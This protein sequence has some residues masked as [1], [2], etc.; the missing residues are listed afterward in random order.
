MTAHKIGTLVAIPIK[1]RKLVNRTGGKQSPYVQLKLGEQK[2]RTRASLIASV[3]VDVFQD[4]LDMKVSVFDEGKKGELVGDGILLLN[5]V[6]DKGELDVWFPIK[7]NGSAAGDIYF[8][9]TF[10]AAAPPPAAGSTPPPATPQTQIHTPLRYNQPGF[11][12]GAPGMHPL[13]H[14]PPVSGYGSPAINH[15][16]NL[17][18]PSP[19][20]AGNMYQAP[21]PGG[22]MPNANARPFPPAHQQPFPPQQ[23]GPGPLPFG[24]PPAVSGP[25]FNQPPPFGN[26][27]PFRPPVGGAFPNPASPPFGQPGPPGSGPGPIGGGFPNAMPHMPQPSFNNNNG[28]N[29]G[30]NNFPPHN[31]GPNNNFSP[32]NNNMGSRFPMPQGPGGPNNNMNNGPNFLQGPGG[33]PNT[34]PNNAPSSFPNGPNNNNFNNGPPNSFPGGNISNHNNLNNNNNFGRNNNNNMPSGPSGNN[35]GP[36]TP[37]MQYNYSL[38]GSFP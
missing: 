22:Y 28:P 16:M 37:L 31:N 11:Q 27:A 34:F 1:G 8:E 30:P 17:G 18:G 24:G 19:P 6:I 20:Y 36:V 10:Y 26:N 15:N 2:K 23:P 25:G 4:Q 32:N 14:T 13:P 21:G 9:L 29:N 5:E 33:P 35:N 3:R 12:G 38:G 7:F